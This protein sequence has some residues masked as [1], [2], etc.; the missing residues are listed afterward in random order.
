MWTRE[1]GG[2]D[3]AWFRRRQACVTMGGGVDSLF[4]QRAGAPGRLWAARRRAA[5]CGRC[6]FA[7]PAVRDTARSRSG[8]RGQLEHAASAGR[9]PWVSFS[10]ASAWPP[11]QRSTAAAN[12]RRSTWGAGVS[13]LDPPRVHANVDASGDAPLAIEQTI[14]P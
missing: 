14:I 1:T 11:R 12:G 13:P 4:C 6:F 5:R 9:G 7:A 3:A 8:E 10:P 2:I